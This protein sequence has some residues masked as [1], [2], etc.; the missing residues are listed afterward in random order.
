MFDVALDAEDQWKDTWRETGL[1][2][3]YTCIAPDLS[4]WNAAMCLDATVE[5]A[6]IIAYQLLPK[7]EEKKNH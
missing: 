1:C 4:I 2:T 5:C 6:C 3:E 7:A